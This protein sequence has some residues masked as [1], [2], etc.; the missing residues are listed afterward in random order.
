LLQRAIQ[1]RLMPSITV[2]SSREMSQKEAFVPEVQRYATTIFP[3]VELRLGTRGNMNCVYCLVGKEKGYSRPFNEIIEDLRFAREQNLEKVSLTG[4]EPTLHKDIL[5]IIASAKALGFKQ[6]T[7]VTNAV[8]LLEG[9]NFERVVEAGITSIGISLDTNDKETQKKLW[10]SHV[11]DKVMETFRRVARFTP[12]FGG[13]YRCH[14]K[15][16][17]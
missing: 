4:G 14:N 6:I 16:E 9:R 2:V 11:F 5:K 13:K 17:L 1:Y 10:R 3:C 7:P 12:P 8:L 15:T